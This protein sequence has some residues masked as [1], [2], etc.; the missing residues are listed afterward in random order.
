MRLYSRGWP[1]LAAAL[2]V[3]SCTSDDDA[4]AR[5]CHRWRRPTSSR[6]RAVCRVRR[7]RRRASRPIRR[8]P[9]TRRSPPITSRAR[10]SRRRP[11][12]TYE[13]CSDD[14]TSR[15]AWSEEVATQTNPYLD[16]VATDATAGY[17]E[18]GRV[19]RGSSDLYVRSACFAARIS[20]APASTSRRRRFAG[21]FNERPLD[22]AAL[23]ALSS[24][25]G[26][27]GYN[28]AGHAVLASE[29]LLL[30]HARVDA[31]DPRARP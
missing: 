21:V 11:R 4:P 8:R 20:I 18:F 3:T 7:G 28:N 25:C 12:S 5:S 14:W 2:A 13:V 31:R 27:H 10:S 9:A 6:G 26:V 16:L 30:A 22:A 23:R 15:L 1:A 19:P 29:T 17:F 24:T